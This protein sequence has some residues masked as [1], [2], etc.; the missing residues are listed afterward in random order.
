MFLLKSLQMIKTIIP[1]VRS[2]L[3]SFELPK[4]QENNHQEQCH[5]CA[6]CFVL[7]DRGN[8]TECYSERGQFVESLDKE[9]KESRTAVEFRRCVEYIWKR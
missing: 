7:Q 2:H 3:K 1:R 6:V 8:G 9:I 4:G 5:V